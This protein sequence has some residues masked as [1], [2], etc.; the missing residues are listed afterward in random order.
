MRNECKNCGIGY[1]KPYGIFPLLLRQYV[2]LTVTNCIFDK[3]CMQKFWYWLLEI[4]RH[5]SVIATTVCTFNSYKLYPLQEMNAN[6]MVLAVGK[7]TAY[8]R[9]CYDSMY[10]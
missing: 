7:M 6:I 5:I 4:L 1:W 2:H 3:N 9:Y 10:I 8:F